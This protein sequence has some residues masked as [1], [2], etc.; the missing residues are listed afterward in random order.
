MRDATKANYQ[1]DGERMINS[2]TALEMMAEEIGEPMAMNGCLGL[3]LLRP[4]IRVWLGRRG[5]RTDTERS[6][7]N[8]WLKAW[9]SYGQLIP[10]NEQVYWLAEVTPETARIVM[11]KAYDAKEPQAYLYDPNTGRIHPEQQGLV[12]ELQKAAGVLC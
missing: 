7:L 9:V 12:D 8:R 5:F 10:L 11:N 1:C 6:T 2:A 4:K 3:G